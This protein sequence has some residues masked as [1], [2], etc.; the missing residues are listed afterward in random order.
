MDTLTTELETAATERAAIESE[1]ET[2]LREGSAIRERVR[3]YAQAGAEPQIG[4]AG[5]F[6]GTSPGDQIGQGLAL[7]LRDNVTAIDKLEPRRLEARRLVR[8]TERRIAAERD[9]TRRSA[10]G[11]EIAAAERS[12]LAAKEATRRAEDERR[13]RILA[14]FAP[15]GIVDRLGSRVAGLGSRLA[16][17]S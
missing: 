9:A 13:A 2:L 11:V 7:A 12:R 3:L 16:G 1:Y 17:R 4:P 8:A 6:V 10:K 5:P 14:E 15:A